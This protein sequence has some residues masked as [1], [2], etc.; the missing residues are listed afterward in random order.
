MRLSPH[1]TLAELTKTTTGLDNSPSSSH[2]ANLVT[3]AAA[4]EKVR[5]VL[6]NNP[7]QIN[8]GYRSPEVNKAV[9]GARASAHL[10][11]QAVDFTCPGFGTPLAVC[12]AI[13]AAGIELDQLI[14]EYGRWVHLGINPSPRRQYLTVDKLGTRPGLLE[15]RK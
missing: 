15:V 1:F 7:I 6:G 2:L 14:H 10:T 4:L 3:L 8:S 9:G 12:E 11:G 5:A 13:K